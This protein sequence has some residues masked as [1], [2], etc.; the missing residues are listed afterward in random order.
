MSARPLCVGLVGGLVPNSPVAEAALTMLKRHP[1]SVVALPFWMLRG[2]RVLAGEVADRVPTAGPA[3]PYRESVLSAVR[4]ARSEGRSVVLVSTVPE[5]FTT[6]IAESLDFDE[7]LVVGSSSEVATVLGERFGDGGFDFVG[8]PSERRAVSGRAESA[9]VARGPSVPLTRVLRRTLRMHQW[10]KN[11]LIFLPVLGA[12]RFMDTA[13]ISAALLA[14]VAF[15]LV[16]SSVYVVNDAL[17]L[18]DDRRHPTKR[19]RPLASGALALSRAPYFLAALLL[20]AG[21][22]TILRP[23]AFRITLG[24]Y[25]FLTFA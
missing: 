25:L 5:D 11:L 18:R 21:S 19:T 17:D 12:Q 20:V 3:P 8:S 10:L 23:P 7:V 4:E 13:S 2:R 14:F 22:I 16:A 24:V 9:T 6:P 15:S 1:S